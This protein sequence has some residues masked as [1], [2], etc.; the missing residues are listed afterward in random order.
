MSF[1]GANVIS[2]SDQWKEQDKENQRKKSGEENG[3]KLDLPSEKK[4]QYIQQNPH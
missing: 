3:D 2:N 1:R 4:P